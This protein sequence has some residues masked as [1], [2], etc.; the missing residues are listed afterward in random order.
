MKNRGQDCMIKTE[1]TTSFSFFLPFRVLICT[2]LFALVVAFS[3]HTA[4]AQVD[5]SKV[6]FLINEV[7]KVL[8]NDQHQAI[9]LCD[10]IL[11][12]AK[13][14]YHNHYLAQ[15][16]RFKGI[17]YD[18]LGD[19]AKSMYEYDRA[20]NYAVL[21]SDTVQMANCWVSKGIIHHRLENYQLALDYYLRGLVVHERYNNE[22]GIVGTS[23]NIGVVYNK[24]N[25]HEAAL[26]LYTE[27]L[28]KADS[29]LDLPRI[30]AMNN[31]LGE[32][33]LS[34]GQLDNARQAL[35]KAIKINI[36]Q[37]DNYSLGTSFKT[38]VLVWNE[39]EQYDSALYYN[40]KS[41]ELGLNKE[42]PIETAEAKLAEGDI[43][44]NLSDYNKVISVLDTVGQILD[45]E[46][47]HN[48]L[49]YRFHILNAWALDS[50][51]NYQEAAFH[52][53]KANIFRD[54]IAFQETSKKL[55]SVGLEKNSK[56]FEYKARLADQNQEKLIEQNEQQQMWLI[57]N[58]VVLISLLIVVFTLYKSWNLRAKY[59][60]ILSLRND[61]LEADIKS[62]DRMLRVLAHDFRSPLATLKMAFE[63]LS[64][65]NLSD[66]DRLTLAGKSNKHLNNTLREIDQLLFW[67]MR[68]KKILNPEL[69]QLSVA[70]DSA[71]ELHQYDLLDK[72]VEI[73]REN[74]EG[75]QILF[76]KINFQV[77]CRNIVHNSL[78]YM[79]RSGQ[80]FVKYSETNNHRVLSFEDNGVGIEP[81]LLQWINEKEFS[82]VRPDNNKGT[83]LGIE[84]IFD[85]VAQN[86]GAIR[87]ESELGNGTSVI[88]TLPKNKA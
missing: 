76:D 21:S 44:L 32:T 8:F 25:M 84:L 79:G 56:E 22:L 71:Q 64:Q 30:A 53:L 68:D 42:H 65:P 81:G 48:E 67:L 82:K 55:L 75:V 9:E 1:C 28:R 5:T 4:N 80:L 35:K 88:I 52:Y 36:E 57:I 26:E 10:D 51:K 41:L 11:G 40:K 43:Y 24:L 18:I 47:K 63:H 66:T 87:Y 34:L 78:K 29:T 14:G 62:T 39:L 12:E 85:I 33:Y 69:I 15:A 6:E 20:E 31:N 17:A 7:K 58:S 73:V 27:N 2:L 50:L 86:G 19:Y 72:N 16:H 61:E 60:N 59:N 54:S 70:I 46:V 49:N 37:N 45:N 23:N 77:L 38:Y 13:D 74:L 3:P 83:G